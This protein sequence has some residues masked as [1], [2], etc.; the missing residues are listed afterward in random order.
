MYIKYRKIE[1]RVMQTR[2]LQTL[3]RIAQMGSFAAVAEDMNTT[4]STVSMQMRT[5][6]DN[7]GVE[8]F[9][10]SFRPPKLTPIGRTV[11]KHAANVIASETELLNACNIAGT[12]TG[13]WHIGFIATASVRLLPQFLVRASRD[14]PAAEF[15]IETGL[16]ELLET[17][18]LHGQLDAAI[19]TASGEAQ[20]G[21]RYHILKEEALVYAVPGKLSGLPISE[22]VEMHAFIQFNPGSGIGK[23][24][25]SHMRNL[26]RSG[27]RRRI[28][29][30]S[31]EA[32]MECVNEGL[33]FTL[34]SELDVIRYANA[35]V[36]I[37]RPTSKNISRRLVL[38]S[39]DKSPNAGD[40]DR[41]AELFQEVT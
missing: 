8:L 2:S 11:A 17:R 32:I 10:R 4:L 31:V 33:G 12:L 40:I 41:L 38:V 29:L 15:E 39:A 3:Y 7:L 35:D 20:P 37:V 24:I 28:V 1:L 23:L 34:L 25:A 9:D 21:L 30:D 22:L 19:V 26:N 14:A 6:E 5:L 27:I 36:T 13:A 16:S 18:V